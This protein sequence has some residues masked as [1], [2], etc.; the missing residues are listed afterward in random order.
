MCINV[1]LVTSHDFLGTKI[2]NTRNLSMTSISSSNS[3]VESNNPRPSGSNYAEINTTAPSAT[4]RFQKVNSQLT[5]EARI[6][7]LKCKH[8]FHSKCLDS[9]RNIKNNCPLCRVELSWIS[10]SNTTDFWIPFAVHFPN[11]EQEP[12]LKISELLGEEPGGID[13]GE[14]RREGRGWGRGKNGRAMKEGRGSI[15]FIQIITKIV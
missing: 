5:K 2:S 8:I 3:R 12:C 14:S 13:W 4:N 11:S 7:R 6:Y 10:N 1:R 9:W 15:I